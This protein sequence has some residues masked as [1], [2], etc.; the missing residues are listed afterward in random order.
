M[1]WWYWCFRRYFK[2]SVMSVV[3]TVTVITPAA[4]REMSWI[5]YPCDNQR[6]LVSN[7]RHNDL[8]DKSSTCFVWYVLYNCGNN[9]IQFTIGA[10]IDMVYANILYYITIC[11]KWNSYMNFIYNCNVIELLSIPSFKSLQIIA[12]S[13][14]YYNELNN[15]KA[16][17]LILTISKS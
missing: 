14:Q 11:Y 2:K 1:C 4:M 15:L 16:Y 17:T 12:F 13:F 6:M 10:N 7:I 9:W 5:K 3:L 8:S